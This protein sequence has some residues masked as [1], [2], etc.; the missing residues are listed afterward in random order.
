MDT[1]GRRDGDGG[2]PAGSPFERVRLTAWVRGDVQGVGFR[3]W[4]RAQAQE[5]GLSG[6]ARNLPDGRVEVVAEGPRV[7]CEEL[8]R[9]LAE[10]AGDSGHGRAGRLTGSGRPGTVTG[11]AERWDAPRGAEGFSVA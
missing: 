8:L 5:L 9:R 4:T 7:E 2:V 1:A 6:T 3:W 10:G 11:V